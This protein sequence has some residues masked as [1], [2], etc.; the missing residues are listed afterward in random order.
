[1]SMQGPDVP[2][3]SISQIGIPAS[4]LRKAQVLEL[5][6]RAADGSE[7]DRFKLP[8]GERV[9]PT[10]PSED[11]DLRLQ[12]NPAIIFISGTR[13]SLILDRRTGQIKECAC[14]GRR[15]IEGGPLLTFGR[16]RQT[17]WSLA[18]VN[19]RQLTRS[20]V[21]AVSGQSVHSGKKIGLQF[22]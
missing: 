4:A 6:F 3:H 11:G 9:I 12:T 2:P 8:V 14:N 22:E 18:E 15:I 5:G 20:V 16:G 1:G 21:I 7:V 13:F 10:F 17:E 19:I